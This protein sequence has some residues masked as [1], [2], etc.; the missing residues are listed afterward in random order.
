M[1]GPTLIRHQVIQVR[2][3][4]QER[5]LAATWMVKPFHR[6]QFLSTIIE[7]GL[8]RTFDNRSLSLLRDFF[9]VSSRSTQPDRLLCVPP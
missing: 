2:Q 7:K 5:L 6:E 1:L 4:R 3:P 9:S 8:I